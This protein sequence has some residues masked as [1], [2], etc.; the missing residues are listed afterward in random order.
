MAIK[1]I[2]KSIQFNEFDEFLKFL[3]DLR[4][5]KRTFAFNGNINANGIE[6]FNVNWSSEEEV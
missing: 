2:D 3:T 4:D 1:K 6:T 5:A